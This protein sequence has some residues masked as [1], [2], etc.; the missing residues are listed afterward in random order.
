[1]TIGILARGEASVEKFEED[2]LEY[3]CGRPDRFVS[4][5]FEIPYDG[6]S[7]GSCPDFVVVD[8]G[9]HTIYVVEVTVAADVRCLGG[10]VRERETRWFG[11]LRAHLQRLSP[12]FAESIWDHHVSVFVREEQLTPARRMFETD[13]DVSILSLD[14]TVFSWR[15]DWREGIPMNPLREP[16]KERRTS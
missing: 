11:P 12:I 1:L 16:G 4:T 2:V 13:G 3:I 15:W 8:F 5:Q 6:F 9:D 7:G 14:G 10:R